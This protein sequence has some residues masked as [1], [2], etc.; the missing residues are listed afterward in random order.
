[1]LYKL[2]PGFVSKSEMEKVPFVGLV[3]KIIGSIFL[4]R[5]SEHDRKKTVKNLIF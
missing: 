2:V 1:M 5:N 4:D 3:A